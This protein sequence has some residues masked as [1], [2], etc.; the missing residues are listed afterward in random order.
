M[1]KKSLKNWLFEEH[2]NDIQLFAAGIFI[3]IIFFPEEIAMFLHLPLEVVK[4][5]GIAIAALGVIFS[6]TAIIARKKKWFSMFI[7]NYFLLK[8]RASES[9]DPYTAVQ[10][11][12]LLTKTIN[13][14]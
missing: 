6:I 1:N 8:K 13:I 10:N 14:N 5:S 4:L 2:Y 12:I 7:E 9:E 11:L 3:L